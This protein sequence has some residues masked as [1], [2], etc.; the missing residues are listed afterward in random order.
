MVFGVDTTKVKISK[1]SDYFDPEL[2][3]TVENAEVS[4]RD[5]QG[6]LWQAINDGDSEYSLVFTPEI[7]TEYTLRVTFDNQIYEA[8]STMLD[9]VSLIEIYSEF[10]PGNAFND[11]GYFVYFRFQD[12][13]N[14][15]NY[16]KIEHQIDGVIQNSGDDLQILNDNLFDNIHY[17]NNIVIWLIS[18]FHSSN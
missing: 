16:Y 10:E 15:E 4:L 18:P 5:D 6:Q 11:E 1:S 9:Q 2:P 17:Q 7:N 12:P 13:A 14:A 8:K 3:E